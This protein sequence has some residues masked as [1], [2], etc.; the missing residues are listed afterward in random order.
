LDKYIRCLKCWKVAMD[1]EGIPY[2]KEND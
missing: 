1:K 2:K